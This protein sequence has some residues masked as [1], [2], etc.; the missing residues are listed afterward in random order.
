MAKKK[1]EDAVATKSKFNVKKVDGGDSQIGYFINTT[2]STILAL[3]GMTVDLAKVCQ[4][5]T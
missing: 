4:D 2:K 3:P 5:Y 1:K